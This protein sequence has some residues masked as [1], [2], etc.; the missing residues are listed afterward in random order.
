VLSS[1]VQVLSAC[2]QGASKRTKSLLRGNY[3]PRDGY[4]GTAS[5]VLDRLGSRLSKPFA[6]SRSPIGRSFRVRDCLRP[7]TV[8][9]A[10]EAFER[11]R[12]VWVLP[13]W[14]HGDGGLNVATG[15]VGR[16]ML[17]TGTCVALA[18]SGEV[19]E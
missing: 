4:V 5:A 14:C 17:R 6:N 18:G 9:P 1:Y 10:R 7:G 12:A 3:E 8:L 11:A 15:Y 19:A 13:R 2:C 16:T